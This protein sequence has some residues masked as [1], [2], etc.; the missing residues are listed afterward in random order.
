MKVVRLAQLLAL[1]YGFQSEAAN[2]PVSEDRI[3]AEVKRDILDS[4]RNYFSR[5]AKN[6]ML[7]YAADKGDPLTVEL[8]YKMDKL[9]RDIDTLPPVKLIKSLNELLAIMYQMKA[10]PAKAARQTI[11]DSLRGHP[12]R[13]IQHYLTTFE[14]FLSKAFSTLQK[15]AVKLQV[16][17]PDVAV[18]GGGISR[19]RG[20]LAIKDIMD[21][22]KFTPA[23]QNYGLDSTDIMEQF[24]QDPELKAR[25]TTL[26]NSIN[27]GH[28]P[29][30][31]PE[32]N[33]IAQEIK[34][35]LDQKN[36]TNLPALEQPELPPI[37]PD[38]EKVGE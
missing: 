12:E 7:Q 6:S 9:V 15:A 23:F 11:R 30:D 28:S 27:R 20:E 33:R 31:G 37:N 17:V 13:T 8:T 21:F 25:L 29:L 2:A 32:V 10:D 1:K 38:P 14:G 34:Q 26:I 4:Y 36:Q 18:H 16:V 19:Q 24:L 3:V 5:S 22:V 35:K